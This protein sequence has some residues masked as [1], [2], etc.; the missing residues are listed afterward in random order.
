MS[1]KRSLDINRYYWGIVI[2]HSSYALIDAGWEKERFSH[3]EL[4]HKFWKTVLN[5]PS[6]A[7][8]SNKQFVEFIEDIKRICAVYLNYYIPDPKE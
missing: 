4:V 1:S 8:L 7:D 3:H 2:K 5:T 6:T